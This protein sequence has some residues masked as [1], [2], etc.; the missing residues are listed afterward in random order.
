MSRKEVFDKL[1]KKILAAGE[2][3]DV[4]KRKDLESL[5][6]KRY[7]SGKITPAEYDELSRL[8]DEIL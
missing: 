3:Y 5:L 7:V 2:E 6:Y 8:V 1:R 4:S